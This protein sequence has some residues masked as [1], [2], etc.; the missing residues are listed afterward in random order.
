[1]WK[2]FPPEAASLVLSLVPTPGR[3]IGIFRWGGSGR[4][5]LARKRGDAGTRMFLFS[6]RAC[7]LGESVASCK[8]NL[9]EGNF[10]RLTPGTAATKLSFSVILEISLSRPTRVTSV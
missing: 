1:M 6:V 7:G 5:G 3:K 10:L 2:C 9:Y 8:E 4:G